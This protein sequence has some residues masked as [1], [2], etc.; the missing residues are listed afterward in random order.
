MG[1]ACS[2][3]HHGEC[4]KLHPG[5]QYTSLPL[6]TFTRISPVPIGPS[7]VITYGPTFGSKYGSTNAEP[8]LP[9]AVLTAFK[10]ALRIRHWS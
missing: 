10:V 5:S 9:I 3:T 1:C 2:V 6:K 4:S 7:G 8:P